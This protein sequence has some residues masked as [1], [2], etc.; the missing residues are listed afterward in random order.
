M[1]SFLFHNIQSHLIFD[2]LLTGAVNRQAAL[3]KKTMTAQNFVSSSP[4]D[5]LKRIRP[6]PVV[7]SSSSNFSSKASVQEQRVSKQFAKVIGKR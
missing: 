7:A 1:K 3:V 6:Q 5:C 4:A 2:N